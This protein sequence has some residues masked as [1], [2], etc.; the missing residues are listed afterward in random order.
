MLVEMDS[1]TKSKVD[2]FVRLL[3]EG[4][5]VF[6]PTRALNLGN[7]LFRL[8]ATSD[9]DPETETWEFLPGSEV[10]G[11]IRSSESGRHLIAVR[12]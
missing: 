4:T 10:R 8:E 5:E 2:I 11:E 6:R 7:G 9:Y 12:P 1:S 3:D